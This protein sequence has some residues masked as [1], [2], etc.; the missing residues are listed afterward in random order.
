M[1]LNP[2]SIVR[3]KK[4]LMLELGNA[5]PLVDLGPINASAP[6]NNGGLAG[7]D[8]TAPGTATDPVQANGSRAQGGFTNTFGDFTYALYLNNTSDTALATMLSQG[9]TTLPTNAI[10]FQ[11][12]GEGS[13]N[14]G[15][16]VTTANNRNG[17]NSASYWGARAGVEK[18]AFA[19]FATVGLSS[20]AKNAAGD[21]FKGTLNLNLGATYKMDNMT[22][23]GKFLSTGFENTDNLVPGTAVK[24]KAPSRFNPYI[25]TS[26]SNINV[27]LAD[28][29]TFS[30]EGKQSWIS[31]GKIAVDG[32]MSILG[33]TMADIP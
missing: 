27:D 18:D 5:D 19:G 25:L 31:H 29:L 7:T 1:F 17:A 4:K 6:D 8:I 11:L 22:A 30:G 23:F 20:K 14:W 2:A 3:Y 13:V 26:P 9:Y 33:P 15:V 21:E 16:G 28:I 32:S 10:E 24:C 12:A